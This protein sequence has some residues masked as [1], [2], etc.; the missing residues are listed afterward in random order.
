M[1]AGFA[2]GQEV[3]SFFFKYG[4]FGLLGIFI[5]TIMLGAIIYKTL[6]LILKNDIKDYKEFLEKI[7]KNDFLKNIINII[8][9]I[10]LIISFYIM[11]AGFGA[12]MN[13][14]YNFQNFLGCTILATTCFFILKKNINGL[15]KINEALIPVL[16]IVISLIGFYNIRNFNK[17]L[18]IND[19]Q[20]NKW[21]LDSILYASYNSIA[22]IPILISTKKYVKSSKNIKIIS[23]ISMTIILILLINIYFLL[24]NVDVITQIPSIYAVKKISNKLRYIYG[25]IILISILTTAISVGT[26]FINNVTK[27]K[28]VRNYLINFICISSILFSNLG[29]S[30]LINIFYPIL[31]TLGLIQIVFIF[32]P[33]HKKCV[34]K[35]IKK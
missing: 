23:I 5:T 33:K 8:V 11:I 12:F 14:E 26:S 10:Y 22:L 20:N 9:N 17:G 27:S 30:N 34:V 24:F 7:I 3:S 19:I 32:I 25:V 1:G 6:N 4:K 15:V 18:K 31:G 2:S 16:I 21:I 28:K 29:F 13:Q 35:N